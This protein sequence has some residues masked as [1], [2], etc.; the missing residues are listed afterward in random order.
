M[1]VF[2][3]QHQDSDFTS[4]LFLASWCFRIQQQMNC[5]HVDVNRRTEPSRDVWDSESAVTPN[6]PVAAVKFPLRLSPRRF[7][8]LMKKPVKKE[9]TAASESELVHPDELF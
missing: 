2:Q 9:A 7:L 6:C 4:R 8:S 3:K 5:K 1:M